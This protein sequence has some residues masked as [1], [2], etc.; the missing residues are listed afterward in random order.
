MVWALP[1][2]HPISISGLAVDDA[3]AATSAMPMFA[4]KAVARALAEE[5]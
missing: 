3:L 4:G 5:F 2:D 1:A